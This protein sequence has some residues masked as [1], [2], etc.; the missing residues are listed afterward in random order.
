MPPS[1]LHYFEVTYTLPHHRLGFES[2]GGHMGACNNLSFGVV[3]PD[4][5][6]EIYSN[7][8]SLV[9]LDHTEPQLHHLGSETGATG[10]FGISEVLDIYRGRRTREKASYG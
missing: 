7:K 6:P 4:V 8:S 2:A 9:R 1:G 3:G 10:L 5:P